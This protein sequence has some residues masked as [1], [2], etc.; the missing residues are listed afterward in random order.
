MAEL[1]TL[2]KENRTLKGQLEELSK[3]F[4]M[5]NE[6]I[7]SNPRYRDDDKGQDS[8]AIQFLSDKYDDLLSSRDFEKKEL[9]RLHSRLSEIAV[10]VDKI[11]QELD[12]IE[13]Y[14]YQYNLKIIGVPEI[15]TKE[16]SEQSSDI[17]V[18]LFNVMGAKVSIHD[19]DIAHRIPVRKVESQGK[20]KPIICKFIRRL[21]KESVMK[22]RRQTGNITT[23][24]LRGK[25]NSADARI[26]RERNNQF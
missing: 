23:S 1:R 2:R 11:E 16:S 24:Q 25:S 19:I 18:K 13:N 21:A 9:Q 17:C 8:T 3:E 4:E 14:S 15:S 12:N 6:R 22:L 26:T 5:L 20:P 7:S 10:Q